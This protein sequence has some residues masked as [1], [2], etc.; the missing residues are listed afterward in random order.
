[1]KQKSVLGIDLGGTKISAGIVNE[2]K[3]EKNISVKINAAGSV[4]EV[5]QH[6]FDITG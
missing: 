1:M 4:E 5:L 6:V 2:E 3:I